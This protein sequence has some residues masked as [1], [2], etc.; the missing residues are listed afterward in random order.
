M[1]STL[2]NQ[3]LDE[4][5]FLWFQRSNASNSEYFDLNSLIQLDRRLAGLFRL[6]P[7]SDEITKEENKA[8]DPE[9]PD[10]FYCILIAC[11]ALKDADL[12]TLITEAHQADAPADEIIAALAWADYKSISHVIYKLWESQQPELQHIALESWRLHRTKPDINLLDAINSTHQN[13]TSS[14]LRICGELAL[15]DFYPHIADKLASDDINIRFWASYSC[16]LLGDVKGISNLIESL[17]DNLEQ[18]FNQQ[19]CSTAINTS[20]A[21]I[22]VEQATSWINHLTASNVLPQKIIKCFEVLGSAKF[23]PW[24]IG[25]TQ[26]QQMSPY[27][28]HAFCTIT[29]MD[30]F[31]E[32]HGNIVPILGDDSAIESDE[33]QEL[34]QQLPYSGFNDWW[35]DNKDRFDND[36]RYLTGKEVNEE[37]M[38]F[39]WEKGN[40]KL[41]ERAALELALATPTS[42]LFEHTAPGFR[43]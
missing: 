39:L 30:M 40:Q 10:R 9:D 43:Q 27:A 32:D 19:D 22:A 25:L 14:A 17:N 38:N 34:W 13:I 21:S 18:S 23:I 36:K 1:D 12:I 7:S 2:F 35:E 6:L 3:I 28:S 8:Y 33:Y 24:L 4:A 5:S 42:P 31:S 37:H 29:G 15:P 41:R 26:K 20:F 16:A 11:A